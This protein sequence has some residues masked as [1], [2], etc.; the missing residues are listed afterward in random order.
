[1]SHCH[2]ALHSPPNVSIHLQPSVTF[3]KISARTHTHTHASIVKNI[4]NIRI[5]SKVNWLVGVW[6]AHQPTSCQSIPYSNWNASFFPSNFVL[7]PPLSLSR[8]L[9]LLFP[10]WLVFGVRKYRLE[11]IGTTLTQRATEQEQSSSTN[12]IK[13]ETTHKKKVFLFFSIISFLAPRCVLCR[14]SQYKYIN[15]HRYLHL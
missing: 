8:S 6:C 9:L 14:Q 13:S 10:L 7:C 4:N 11:A 15:P 5:L 3:P 2:L 12:T 1:M